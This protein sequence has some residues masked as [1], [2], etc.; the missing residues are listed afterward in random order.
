MRKCRRRFSIQVL[1]LT[2]SVVLPP[3]LAVR[4]LCRWV[5]THQFF[6]L[7]QLRL[8]ACGCGTGGITTRRARDALSAW[9]GQPRASVCAADKLSAAS[10]F[11]RTNS[12]SL[13]SDAVD[14]PIIPARR[15]ATQVATSRRHSCLQMHTAEFLWGGLRGP[16]RAYVT[17]SI[18]A[19]LPDAY[20]SRTRAG[21]SLTTSATYSSREP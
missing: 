9:H 12:N 11:R 14:S 4:R 1:G 15:R 20:D 3:A 16:C 18:G 5:R 17:R 13:G 6:I 10:C 21:A 8:A 2:R 7:C 19:S